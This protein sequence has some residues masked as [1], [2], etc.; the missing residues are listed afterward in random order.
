MDSTLL[1]LPSWKHDDQNWSRMLCTIYV[2]VLH[3]TDRHRNVQTVLD[4]V[5]KISRMFSIY[6]RCKTLY[7]PLVRMSKTV[8]NRAQKVGRNREVTEM[9]QWEDER[10]HMGRNFLLQLRENSY[11]HTSFCFPEAPSYV[12]ASLSCCCHVCFP[13]PPAI[14]FSHPLTKRCRECK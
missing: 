2:L 7:L 10:M 13:F 1:V 8:R 5:T 12:P 11:F 6:T 3:D 4:I 14:A 9:G